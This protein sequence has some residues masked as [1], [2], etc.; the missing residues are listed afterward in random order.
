MNS[1]LWYLIGTK[2]E[3]QVECLRVTQ[4]DEW[5]GGG[6]GVKE[7]WKNGIWR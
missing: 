2:W 1:F 5:F 3:K 4:K 6:G 7:N